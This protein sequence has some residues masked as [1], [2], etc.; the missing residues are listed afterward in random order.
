MGRLT[1]SIGTSYK[2]AFQEEVVYFNGFS[3]SHTGNYK[4]DI[5]GKLIGDANMEEHNT[6]CFYKQH[7]YE[8]KNN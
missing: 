6:M 5:Q 7:S 4:Q 2:M 3:I 8:G 1:I